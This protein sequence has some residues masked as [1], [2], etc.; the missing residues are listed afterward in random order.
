MAVSPSPAWVH[1]RPHEKKKKNLNTQ[2]AVQLN[3]QK[4]SFLVVNG[5][6]RFSLIAQQSA[7]TQCW[8]N[9]RQSGQLT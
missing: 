7:G 1:A 4:G 3:Q 2:E 9:I 6:F 5:T 8:K